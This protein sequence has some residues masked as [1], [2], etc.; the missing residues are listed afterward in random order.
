MK[1]TCGATLDSVVIQPI[2]ALS[3]ISKGPL[4]AVAYCCEKCGT[5]LGVES[6]PFERDA[7]MKA[8]KETVEKMKKLQDQLMVKICSAALSRKKD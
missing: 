4:K 7:Q 3:G 2:T 8:I 5:I 6:N 1:C